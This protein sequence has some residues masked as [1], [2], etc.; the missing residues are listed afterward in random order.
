MLQHMH[1]RALVTHQPGDRP[2]KP[3][4]AGV[5]AIDQ[6][7]LRLH[8]PKYDPKYAEPAYGGYIHV[9]GLRAVPVAF[10]GMRKLLLELQLNLGA[11]DFV[12]DL[13]LLGLTRA[14]ELH[15]AAAGLTR[16]LHV[17]GGGPH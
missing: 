1:R 12:L 3:V 6:V 15:T 2:H 17:L 16:L 10:S 7:G 13:L 11:L 14:S 4:T 5:E 8:Q 9:V